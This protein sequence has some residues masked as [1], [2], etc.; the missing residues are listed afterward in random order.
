[1][2][3]LTRHPDLAVPLA[4]ALRACVVDPVD[5]SPEAARDGLLA[6]EARAQ[7]LE[8]PLPEAMPRVY[9]A[10]LAGL[11]PAPLDA[12]GDEPAAAPLGGSRLVTFDA[13]HFTEWSVIEAAARSLGWRVRVF[14][15]G[16]GVAVG[17][18]AAF[19]GNE[20]VPAVDLPR[21][22]RVAADLG[23]L[24]RGRRRAIEDALLSG[25]PSPRG[26]DGPI[27]VTALGGLVY[28]G[29]GLRHDVGEGLG[30]RGDAAR[31]AWSAAFPHGRS[32]SVGGPLPS[33]LAEPTRASDGRRHPVG[34][35]AWPDP[36]G[37]PWL[38]SGGL[39]LP[40]RISLVFRLEA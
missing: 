13:L 20:A 10:L 26:S 35:L 29:H 17:I 5:D 36:P 1:V 16:P 19:P 15:W 24:L 4:D 28:L 21:G 9:D 39:S 11:L 30:E 40:E 8:A 32:G 38:Q 23:A 14:A 37:T 22:D 33:R 34:R 27:H 25:L 18:A 6:S 31:A 7:A 12:E 2:Q 3:A